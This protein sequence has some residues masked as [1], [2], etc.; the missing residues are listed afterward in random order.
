MLTSP[1][2]H[3]DVNSQTPFAH[4]EGTGFKVDIGT[5]LRGVGAKFR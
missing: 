3:D 2:N 5:V 4:V 1:D